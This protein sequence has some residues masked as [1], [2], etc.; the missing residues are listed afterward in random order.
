MK[1][2]GREEVWRERWERIGFI[3]DMLIGCFRR[4]ECFSIGR[5]RSM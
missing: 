1:A 2:M 4:L 3:D 5:I